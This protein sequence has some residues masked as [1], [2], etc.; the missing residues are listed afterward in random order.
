M[1]LPRLLVIAGSDSGGGAG[2][3]ADVKTATALGCYAM[4]AVTAVTAQNTLGVQAVHPVPAAIVRAQI[5]S[6]L[7]DIGADAIKVGVLGSAETVSVVAEI[8]AARAKD[9]PIVLDPVIASTSGTAFL[10]EAALAVLKAKLIPLATVITP[11]A[12]EAARLLGLA[13]PGDSYELCAALLTLGSKTAVVTG[14]ETRP[15]W[16]GDILT[17]R[18]DMVFM[19]DSLR[20][21]TPHTHGT[22]CTFSTA[23]ACGLAF[24]LSFAHALEQAHMFVHG[25]IANAPGFGKGHGPLNHMFALQPFRYAAPDEDES[26][27]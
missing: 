10:D 20:I 1:K 15:E 27:S 8:L 17:A 9:I 7:S 25:A 5:E 21:D 26:G 6:C 3:Q 19:T 13:K 12:G 23:L 4:T 16:I 18:D 14:I 22:G 11:N 2:I 24:D